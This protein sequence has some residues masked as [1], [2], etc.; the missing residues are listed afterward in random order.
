[1]VFFAYYFNQ[2]PPFIIIW[3]FN[4]SKWTFQLIVVLLFASSEL[5]SMFIHFKKIANLG[6]QYNS[7]LWT[8]RGKHKV[9]LNA[10]KGWQEFKIL[11][12][13]LESKV[14]KCISRN[15]LNVL[16]STQVFIR[17]LSGP[18][19]RHLT[20]QFSYHNRVATLWPAVI[21]AASFNQPPQPW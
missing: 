4:R 5:K 14:T 8:Q 17:S 1:M 10:K 19:S 16:M 21:T 13:Q 7:S 11:K 6:F 3:L 18:I 2:L 9:M 12:Q 15:A 20:L